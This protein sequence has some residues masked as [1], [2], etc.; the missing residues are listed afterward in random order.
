MK[1]KPKRAK[2]VSLWEGPEIDGISFSLLSKF[3]VCRERFRLQVVE[4]L[5]EREPFNHPLE[6][7][8]CWHE[9]EEV[10][11]RDGYD[12]NWLPA[13]QRY[14]RKLYS[15]HP[16]AEVGIAKTYNLVKA[17]FP[18]YLQHWAKDREAKRREPVLQEEKFR[19]PYNLLSGRI[20]LLR[21]KWDSVYLDKEGYWLQENKTKGEVDEVGIQATLHQ[22]LQTM[23]YFIAFQTVLK[24]QG[25]EE[26]AGLAQVKLSQVK[27]SKIKGVLYNVVR[28]PLGDRHAIRQKKS[29]TERQ[30]Y[31]RVA[32]GIRQDPS[33]YFLRWK[34]RIH[35][36]DVEQFRLRVFNPILEQLCDW[37]EWIRENPS[38]PWEAST[39]IRRGW[40]KSTASPHWQS[41]WGVY[42]SL[43]SGFRGDYFEYMTQGRTSGLTKITELF[44]ELQ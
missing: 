27:L 28:R 40:L 39:P 36:Q 20:I 25:M 37:W 1:K 11:A 14:C 9:A 23:L 15:E 2:P 8:S 6:F 3:L 38:N 4:G 33:H 44:P 13:V 7:G 10:I 18:L 5:R 42:N 30:F 12:G 29:E 26:H 19:V 32:D 17:A 43:G 22:N 31:K 24:R 21:G 35:P 41:P 16:T 34:C